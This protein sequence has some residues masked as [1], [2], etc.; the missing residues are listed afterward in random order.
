MTTR[1]ANSVSS[2]NRVVRVSFDCGRLPFD[3]GTPRAVKTPRK[4]R[5]RLRWI[6]PSSWRFSRTTV[7]WPTEPMFSRTWLRK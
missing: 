2:M 7:C 1:G 3:P 4:D 5:S 6:K